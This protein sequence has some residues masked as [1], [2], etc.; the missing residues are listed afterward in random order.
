MSLDNQLKLDVE[1]R[2]ARL[3]EPLLTPADAARLLVVKTSWIYEAVRDGRL[4]CVRIGRHIRFL[5]TDLERFV[6]GRRDARR[7]T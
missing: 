5:R 2:F 4:P 3:E 7:P 1:P 6:D